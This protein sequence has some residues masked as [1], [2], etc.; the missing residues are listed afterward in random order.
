[1]EL[2][3]TP[4]PLLGMYA[5]DADLFERV[6][7]R[8]GA[9]ARPDCPVE[10]AATKEEKTEEEAVR[11]ERETGDFPV[12]QENVEW[13]ESRAPSEEETQGS[14]E[15]EISG[16]NRVGE[17]AEDD[18]PAPDDLPCLGRASAGH[19]GQLQQ[20]IREELEGWQLY[21]HLARKV[22]GPYAKTLAALAS[23]KHQRA[24]RLAAAHFLI[25]GVRYWP[26]DKLETPR[27]SSWLGTLRERFSA[28]QRHQHRYRAAAYDTTDPCL[29][30]LYSEL[31]EE[32]GSHAAVLRKVLEGAL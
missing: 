17:R 2:Q 25:A 19:Q 23:E 16:R 8:V 30:E 6:W 18:F 20:Y 11:H 12:T 5:C 10:P 13:E 1:M 4:R 26:T 9:Q 15:Q 22:N 31:A 32:C 29:A 28:E 24:R 27:F 7:E 21:R 14:A 3:Q